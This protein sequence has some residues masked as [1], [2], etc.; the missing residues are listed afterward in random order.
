MIK[1]CEIISSGQAVPQWIGGEWIQAATGDTLEVINPA[2]CE[3]LGELSYGGSTEAISAADAAAEAFPGWSGLPARK[4]SDILQFAAD[5]LASRAGEIGSLLSAETGKRLPEAVGE[6]NFAAEYLRWFAEEARRPAGHVLTSEDPTRRQ[7]TLSRPVGVAAC[8]TPWNFPVSIQARKVAPALA[9]GCTVVARAS[10]KAP[11]AVL[12]LFRALQDA[13]LPPGVANVIHGPAGEQA[14]AL[15]AHPAVR[16]VSFTGSTSVGAHL[17]ELASKRIVR[18]ALELGGD[19]PFIIFADSDIDAAV[20][21]LMI[22][23]FRNN[24]QSCIAANRVFVQSSIL[25]KLSERLAAATS[26]LA[27]GDP[28]DKPHVDLGPLIDTSRVAAVQTLVDEAV[29]A[30]ARWLGP[31]PEMPKGLCFSR[32]GFLVEV[33]D[34]VGLATTEVFGPVSALFPFDTENEVIE[35]A[36]DTEMG[37]A[38]YV[39]TRDQARSWRMAERLEVGIL[40]INHP[41]PSSAFAPLGGVKQSG[42]GREGAHQGLE[43]FTDIRYVSIGL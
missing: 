42:I 14:E 22:A 13:G 8:L 11:L 30:G 37:L 5:L 41:L 43:E 26:S 28:L 29:D 12:E 25:A 38:G 2:N 31:S 23:K 10:E 39:Y 19:A 9:A 21:G 16:V 18:C 34:K 36:N 6:I 4:R 1:T 24:G 7:L 32:P 40:G 35:R 15:L 33:P 27:V 20:E 17:M 3:P